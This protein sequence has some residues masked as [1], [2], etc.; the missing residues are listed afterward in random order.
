[1]HKEYKN[2]HIPFELRYEIGIRHIKKMTK[3]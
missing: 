3:T 2:H 1:M